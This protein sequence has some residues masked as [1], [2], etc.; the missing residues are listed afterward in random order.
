MGKGGHGQE[1]IHLAAPLPVTR[2]HQYTKGE[3]SGEGNGRALCGARCKFHNQEEKH[4]G[5][6]NSMGLRESF[7]EFFSPAWA[8]TAKQPSLSTHDP[9]FCKGSGFGLGSVVTKQIML[10]GVED[11]WNMPR[12]GLECAQE[13][14][15][16]GHHRESEFSISLSTIKLRFRPQMLSERN[17]EEYARIQ[18]AELSV[19]PFCLWEQPQATSSPGSSSSILIPNSSSC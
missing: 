19:C 13:G 16:E 10:P 5:S 18:K 1:D 7:S 17:W 8:G 4:A 11:V 3:R 15:V 6:P 2:L 9:A 14:C 12:M